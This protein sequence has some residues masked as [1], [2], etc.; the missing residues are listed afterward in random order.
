MP[1]PIRMD[2]ECPDFSCIRSRIKEAV[3]PLSPYIAAI[4][5]LSFAP[6]SAADDVA[7]RLSFQVLFRFGFDGKIRTVRDQLAVHPIHRFQSSL[8]LCGRVVPRL[9]ATNRRV[10]QFAQDGNVRRNRKPNVKGL[11]YQL[12]P[13][14]DCAVRPV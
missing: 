8:Q 6:A 12:A 11:A 5:S 14:L 2:K 1:G 9:Q 10:D 13:I 4:Q 3:F 7:A